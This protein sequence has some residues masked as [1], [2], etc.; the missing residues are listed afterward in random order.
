MKKLLLLCCLLSMSMAQLWAQKSLDDCFECPTLQTYYEDLDGDGIGGKEIGEYCVPLNKSWV[1]TQGD[2]NDHFDETAVF[3]EHYNPVTQQWETGSMS[4]G[5]CDGVG[6]KMRI[7]GGGV[8][9]DDVKWS[10]DITGTGLEQ[11][12]IT[13]QQGYNFSITAK[14]CGTSFIFSGTYNSSPDITVYEDTDGDGEGECKEK[15]VCR[16][17]HLNNPQNYVTNNLGAYT[18]ANGVCCNVNTAKEYFEDLDDDKV[19]GKSLGKFCVAPKG[20]VL[21][22]GDCNDNEITIQHLNNC[23]DCAPTPPCPCGQELDKCGVCGG[24]NACADCAG[25]PHGTS[26]TDDNGECCQNPVKYYYDLDKDGH[27]GEY[28]GTFCTPPAGFVTTDDKDCD[29]AFRNKVGGE[30]LD[31]ASGKW[32]SGKKLNIKACQGSKVSVRVTPGLIPDDKVSWRGNVREEGGRQFNYGPPKNGARYRLKARVCRREKYSRTYNIIFKGRY[33]VKHDNVYVYREGQAYCDSIQICTY[34][35]IPQDYAKTK[36]GS[37][38]DAKGE[39]CFDSEAKMCYLD[40]DADGYGDANIPLGRL[41]NPPKHSSTKAGDCNDMDAL[42]HKVNDCGICSYYPDEGKIPLFTDVDGNGEGECPTDEFVCANDF[43]ANPQKYPNLADN[44][45]EEHIDSEGK[46]C[47]P[48]SVIAFYKDGDGDGEGFGEAVYLCEPIEGYVDNNDDCFDESKHVKNNHFEGTVK[49]FVEDKDF[50][51]W[52]ELTKTQHVPVKKFCKGDQVNLRTEIVTEDGKDISHMAEWTGMA[53]GTGENSQVTLDKEGTYYIKICGKTVFYNDLGVPDDTEITLYTDANNNG[54]GG[55]VP[56]GKICQGR[57]E[58]IVDDLGLKATNFFCGVR[59]TGDYTEGEKDIV[60]TDKNGNG[61]RIAKTGEVLHIVESQ[62]VIASIEGECL[63]PYGAHWTGLVSGSGNK[64]SFTPTKD[65]NVTGSI[66]PATA[67]GT[68]N[69]TNGI[70]RTAGVKIYEEKLDSLDLTEEKWFKIVKETVDT[71]YKKIKDW[72]NYDMK[73]VFDYTSIRGHLKAKWKKVDYYADGSKI[74]DSIYI[75]GMLGGQIPLKNN[76]LA[77]K[78]F[79]IGPWFTLAGQLVLDAPT[80]EG[81]GIITYDE[82]QKVPFR[83]NCLN[84]GIGLEGVGGGFKGKAGNKFTKALIN[85]EINL[86]AKFEKFKATPELCYYPNTKELKGSVKGENT[87]LDFCGNI[88][89]HTRNRFTKDTI[90]IVK[91]ED[92]CL[93]KV[94]FELPQWLGGGK[95]EGK[96]YTPIPA[97]KDYYIIEERVIHKFD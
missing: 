85:M 8:T 61:K 76:T 37:F 24:N 5:I 11:E 48:D 17:V 79:P 90:D 30:I 97:A 2:C 46:C 33:R 23:G 88:H 91:T 14:V 39:C 19:G 94:E 80:L 92:G 49:V 16:L 89:I 75:D 18:D 81:G 10:G 87:A 12:F 42:V 32:K 74:G 20:A 63:A 3:S 59:E 66:Y 47:H 54:L 25:V 27:G 34:D 68:G 28:Y 36:D 86:N 43:Y 1:T 55:C 56:C 15:T 65:G 22:S 38:K 44:N 45:R 52:V 13:T 96:D 40:A 69:Y 29:D 62:E 77:T 78:D 57:Y 82:S 26:T 83:Q 6:L 58:Y 50:G 51:K 53:S 73:D 70:H 72:T 4:V 31:P 41:C 35:N 93:S 84:F 67:W 64:L 7:S 9:G 95:F 71:A 21:I 60:L